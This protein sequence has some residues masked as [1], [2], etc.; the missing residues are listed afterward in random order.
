MKFDEHQTII[1]FVK[2]LQRQYTK[3]I[4]QKNFSSTFYDSAKEEGEKK[5]NDFQ[6]EKEMKRE[7]EG[8]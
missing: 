8:E 5:I 1:T 6:I 7:C 4:Q 3:Y 2:A